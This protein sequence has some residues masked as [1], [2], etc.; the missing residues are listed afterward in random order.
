MWEI[1][2]IIIRPLGFGIVTNKISQ[3]TIISNTQNTDI[4][5]II[6][7]IH[8]RCSNIFILPLELYPSRSNV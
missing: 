7:R 5:I 3:V 8:E 6:T 1:I 4:I 2:I